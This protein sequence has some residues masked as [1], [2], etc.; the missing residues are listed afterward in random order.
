MFFPK[1]KLPSSGIKY[2]GTIRALRKTG[3]TVHLLFP[4]TTALENCWF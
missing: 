1:S 4:S 2:F 3:A